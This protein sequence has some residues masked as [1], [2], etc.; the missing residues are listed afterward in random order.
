MRENYIIENLNTKKCSRYFLVIVEI[1]QLDNNLV[2]YVQL[3]IIIANIML[4]LFV[5]KMFDYCWK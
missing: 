1:Y 2:P 3:S 4:C 5:N